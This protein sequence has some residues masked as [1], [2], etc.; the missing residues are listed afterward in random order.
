M[1]HR[2]KVTVDVCSY[3]EKM[4]MD[5]Y[6]S[7]YNLVND[8]EII[9]TDGKY[10]FV[11]NQGKTCYANSIDDFL[12]SP[13]ELADYIVENQKDFDN[14]PI[15]QILSDQHMMESSLLDLSVM[16]TDTFSQVITERRFMDKEEKPPFIHTDAINPNL[17]LRGILFLQEDLSHWNLQG[18]DL[19]RCSF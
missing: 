16:D 19:E 10:S 17:D 8:N 3:L 1:D 11:D 7:L 14:D 2:E 18:R 4:N 15:K 9:N 13:I 6:V 5:E 12:M